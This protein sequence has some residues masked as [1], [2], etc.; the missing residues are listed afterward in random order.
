MPC[1]IGRKRKKKPFGREKGGELIDAGE[2]AAGGGF[3]PTLHP[4][5]RKEK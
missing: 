3:G 5:G 4:K 1:W 2:G